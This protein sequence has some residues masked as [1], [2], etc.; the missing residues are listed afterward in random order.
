MRGR[1]E[2]LLAGFRVTLGQTMP[3]KLVAGVECFL[4]RCKQLSGVE[5]LGIGLGNLGALTTLRMNFNG[6]PGS[7][8][9][10]C[11]VGSLQILDQ[12][13]VCFIFPGGKHIRICHSDG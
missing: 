11:S 7:D 8:R 4:F 9:E 3:A 5:A 1:L 12:G 2:Q 13:A 6:H 10:A